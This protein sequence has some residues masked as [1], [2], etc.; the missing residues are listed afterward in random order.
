MTWVTLFTLRTGAFEECAV[1]IF[2]LGKTPSTFEIRG[3]TKTKMPR[4]VER[5]RNCRARPSVT[6]VMALCEACALPG[7]LR[8]TSANISAIVKDR[9]KR[10]VRPGA[11]SAA[12]SGAVAGATRIQMTAVRW[13]HACSTA[14]GKGSLIVYRR[15]YDD[16]YLYSSVES[17]DTVNQTKF[18]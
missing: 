15:K 18:F 11:H 12:R 7:Q 3:L 5:K 1:G 16:E 17:L 10:L 13:I 6:H 2:A 8:V 9:R 4:A 14:P